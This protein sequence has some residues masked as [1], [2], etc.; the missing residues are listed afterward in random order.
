MSHEFG[1]TVQEIEKDGFPI[2]ER[3]EMLLA[4]DTAVGVS[5]SMGLALIGFAEA[6]SRLRPD[7]LVVLGDRYE[8]MT[9]A[10]AAMVAK[11]PIAHI[12]GGERTEGAI[13]EAIRHSITKMSHMHFVSTEEYRR[14]VIQLGEQP[15][16]V[17]NFGAIGID[18]I[19]KLE[20]MSRDEL[21]QSLRFSFGEQTF[22]LTYHPVTLNKMSP[23][24]AFE[25]VLEALSAFP[26]AKLIITKSNA[27][28]NNSVINE[29]IDRYAAAN[30]NRV[31]AVHSLGQVRYLS[32]VK[33]CNV[34]IG[35]SSSGIIEVP[36]LKRPT[37]NI[38]DRQKG[39]VMGPSI[40][41]VPED[42]DEIIGAIRKALSEPF[43]EVVENSESVYG[44]GNASV[45]IK[46]TLK[47]YPLE[48]ILFKSFYDL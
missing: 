30:P 10:Q 7:I 13:D 14:R 1:Y 15:D 25:Q 37:V 36:V 31:L 9:A 40:I 21:E 41:N 24:Y 46:D 23:K 45:R 26:D 28:P 44:E 43:R 20:L 32:A 11:I 29:M 35:N 17:Y 8:M 22:L 3:I 27:D 33:H 48:G 38:G 39:R 6:Y 47:R 5:K 4:S 18:N 16:A 19:R 34:V 2:H 42:K 12:H